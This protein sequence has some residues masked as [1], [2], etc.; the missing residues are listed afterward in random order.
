MQKLKIGKLKVDYNIRY[1]NFLS[2]IVKE[3]YPL[4]YEKRYE[5]LKNEDDEDDD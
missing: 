2:K 5:E 4:K 3:K 1:S